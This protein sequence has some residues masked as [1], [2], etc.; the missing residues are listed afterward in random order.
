MKVKPPTNRVA[1]YVL[2]TVFLATVL[3]C[4]TVA[5]RFEWFPVKVVI[6]SI[7]LGMLL[8]GLY[9]LSTFPVY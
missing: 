5:Q 7:A 2:N 9:R 6:L 4:I 3:L 8:L 1:P